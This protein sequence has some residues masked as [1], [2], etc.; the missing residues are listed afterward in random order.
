MV[1]RAAPFETL[2]QVKPGNAPTL[3]PFS[4]SGWA[5]GGDLQTLAGHFLPSPKSLPETRLH[6]VAVSHGDQLALCE[7]QPA[8]RNVQGV[9]LFMHGL[10]GHADSSYMLRVA[11]KFL[12]RGWLTFRLN[13]RGA[14]Q[15]KGLA[16]GI[17]H[18]GKSEDLQPVLEKIAALCPDKKIIAAGFSLS[19][20]LLLKYLGEKRHAPPE[21]FCG[22]I[23]LSPPIDLALS[24]QALRRRRNRLYDLRFAGLLKKLVA[25][26]QNA[27]ADFPRFAFPLNLS[28]YRFDQIVTAPLNGFASAE[29]YYARCSAKQF[30]ANISHPVAIIAADNDPFIPGETYLNLPANDFITLLLTRSGGHMGFICA[31]R[32]AGGDYRW[33]DEAVMRWAEKMLVAHEPS[34]KCRRHD[35]NEIEQAPR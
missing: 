12:R 32:T 2:S 28:V 23:A 20:N 8:S 3:P 11:H 9:M 13:H 30:L 19:G 4:A 35:A 33:M 7:N 21:N 15:G 26:Y 5:P 1:N 31:K 18:A 14:G 25:E 17:Y 34:T 6:R 24:A 27:F 10:G 22:A 29:D 16:K